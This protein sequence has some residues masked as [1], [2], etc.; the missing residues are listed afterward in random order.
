MLALLCRFSLLCGVLVYRDTGRSYASQTCL[1][2][3][4]IQVHGRDEGGAT[5]TFPTRSWYHDPGNWDWE[6]KRKRKRKRE[7]ERE[8]ERGWI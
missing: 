6:W 7:R 4:R 1:G 5:D 2:I 8:R 3:A